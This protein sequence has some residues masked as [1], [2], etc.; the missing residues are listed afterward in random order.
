M[1]VFVKITRGGIG[2]ISFE[3][4]PKQYGG[5]YSCELDSCYCIAFVGTNGIVLINNSND[6]SHEV[7]V[8]ELAWVGS[9]SL[10]VVAFREAQEETKT[11]IESFKALMADEG[12]SSVMCMKTKNGRFT[13]K[14]D[15]NISGGDHKTWFSLSIP[16]S[17]EPPAAEELRFCANSIRSL[18][19]DKDT[20]Q[21]DVQFDGINLNDPPLLTENAGAVKTA[22]RL[23]QVDLSPEKMVNALCLVDNYFV[24]LRSYDLQS[25]LQTNLAAQI[26]AA[27]TASLDYKSIA[28]KITAEYNKN[29]SAQND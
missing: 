2:R 3:I 4:T 6:I 14:R 5:L 8:R 12:V 26:E 29:I 27:I 21:G 20:N 15:I 9:L 11:H 16:K 18:V 24:Y 13:V 17:L 1:S 19:Q 22:I 7:I 23:K 28:A 25:S 10:C